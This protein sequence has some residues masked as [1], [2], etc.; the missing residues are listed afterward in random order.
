MDRKSANVPLATINTGFVYGG[1][2][3]HRK[4]GRVW[5]DLII[6]FIKFIFEQKTTKP[7]HGVITMLALTS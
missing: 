1:S 6:E 3:G 4:Q 2:P 5:P 7:A